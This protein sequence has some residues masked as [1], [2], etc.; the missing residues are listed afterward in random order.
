MRR[1]SDETLL[2]LHELQATCGRTAERGEA[3]VPALA[4]HLFAS[5]D[6]VRRAAARGLRTLF[7]ALPADD[8][9][10]LERNAGGWLWMSP[11]TGRV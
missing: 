10:R 4:R 8:L 6:E 5:S 1:L 3:A 9:L 2:V 7:S 11:M